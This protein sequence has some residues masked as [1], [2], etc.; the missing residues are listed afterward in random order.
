MSVI[1]TCPACHYTR[2]PTDDAPSWECP[3][4]QKAYLKAAREIQQADDGTVSFDSTS[5]LEIEFK[6]VNVVYFYVVLSVY[7]VVL[8]FFVPG[9]PTKGKFVFTTLGFIFSLFFYIFTHLRESAVIDRSIGTVTSNRG[10]T[11]FISARRAIV[12]EFKQVQ[13]VMHRRGPSGGYGGYG[14]YLQRIKGEDFLLICCWPV[15]RAWENSLKVARCLNLPI[16]D[17]LWSPEGRSWSVQE[18]SKIPT[19]KDRNRLRRGPNLPGWL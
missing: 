15:D 2:K 12:T 14:I 13:I 17:M 19:W 8:L 9:L 11:P 7:A 10:V 5:K 6:P 4:C 3:N 1:T 18:L 16:N